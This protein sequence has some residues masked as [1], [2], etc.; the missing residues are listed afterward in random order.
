M[1]HINHCIKCQC[2]MSST[3]IQTM[4]NSCAITHIQN[5]PTSKINSGSIKM[6]PSKISSASLPS[7]KIGAEVFEDMNEQVYEQLQDIKSTIDD[8]KVGIKN[9]KEPDDQLNLYEIAV[10]PIREVRYF[11][12]I[13]AKDEKSAVDTAFR[14]LALPNGRADLLWTA[15]HIKGPFTDGS[16]LSIKTIPVK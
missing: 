15:N 3:R 11:V 6:G 13:L 10:D 14:V 16:V 2:V 12:M 7:M 1:R 8:I 5:K 4:C 9:R